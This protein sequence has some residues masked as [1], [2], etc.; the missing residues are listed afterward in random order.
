M[1]PDRLGLKDDGGYEV[2]GEEEEE[3]EKEMMGE[4]PMDIGN[5]PPPT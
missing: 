2:E 4:D 1:R 3:E 5:I